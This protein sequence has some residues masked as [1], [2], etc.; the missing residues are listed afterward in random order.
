MEARAGFHGAQ[1][2]SAQTITVSVNTKAT[3]EH[4][5]RIITGNF[6]AQAYKQSYRK[7]D[8]AIKH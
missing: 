4:I 7:R 2:K 3:P 5:S 8:N 1:T 6:S